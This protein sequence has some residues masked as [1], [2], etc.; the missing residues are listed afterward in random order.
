MIGDLFNIDLLDGSYE[1][2]RRIMC[3]WSY[4]TIAS[5]LKNSVNGS[6]SNTPRKIFKK[7][8][9]HNCAV[10]L[11]QPDD[12]YRQLGVR[13]VKIFSRARFHSYVKHIMLKELGNSTIKFGKQILD[14]MIRYYNANL[15]DKIDDMV[16]KKYGH[17]DGDNNDGNN[18]KKLFTCEEFHNEFIGTECYS[19]F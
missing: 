5:V 13:T 1:D 2:V 19:D 10:E 16:W 18:N 8:I 6:V 15:L 14:I 12:Y 3:V 17:N 9:R 7:N 4:E 11:G